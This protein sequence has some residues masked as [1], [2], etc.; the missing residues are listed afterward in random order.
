MALSSLFLECKIN[1]QGDAGFFLKNPREEYL[2]LL[3]SGMEVLNNIAKAKF[4]CY[5]WIPIRNKVAGFD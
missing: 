2:M 3:Y 5:F 4:L 1:T